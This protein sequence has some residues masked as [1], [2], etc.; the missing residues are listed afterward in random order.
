[1]E[2]DS[3]GSVLLG[4]GGCFAFHWLRGQLFQTVQE[5][6]G[7]SW[8]VLS[9]ASLAAKSTLAQSSGHAPCIFTGIPIAKTEP[10]ANPTL[11]PATA[12]PT[13]YIHCRKFETYRK[14]EIVSLTS[15]L[16][17]PQLLLTTVNVLAHQPVL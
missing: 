6:Q 8:P 17:S 12:T 11:L 10:R 3:G 14:A 13:L 5:V 2:E 4:L 15:H 9:S 1:M 16:W 7:C